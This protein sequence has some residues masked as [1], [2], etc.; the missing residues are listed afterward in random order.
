MIVRARTADQEPV[1]RLHQLLAARAQRRRSSS[2][3]IPDEKPA[4]KFRGVTSVELAVA[5]GEKPPFQVPAPIRCS[6][7]SWSAC[8]QV[9]LILVMAVPGGAVQRQR[10]KRVPETV[11]CP[12]LLKLFR[13]APSKGSA[14]AG[15]TQ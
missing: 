1:S 11:P 12:S 7:P 8:H 3:G 13:C 9:P 4:T 15:V 5:K 14:L 2:A 10:A 6:M